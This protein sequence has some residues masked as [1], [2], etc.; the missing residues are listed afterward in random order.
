MKTFIDAF[1]CDY[2]TGDD[3]HYYL[4]RDSSIECLSD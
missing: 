2:D 1:V 3:T 4:V